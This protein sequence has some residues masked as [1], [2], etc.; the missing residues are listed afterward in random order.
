MNFSQFL[1]CFALLNCKLET[2]TSCCLAGVG[3]GGWDL[4]VGQFL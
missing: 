2:P 1:C 4:A 3:V